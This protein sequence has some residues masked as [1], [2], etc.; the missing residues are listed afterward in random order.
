[1]KNTNQKFIIDDKF[2]QF[3]INQWLLGKPNNF[4]VVETGQVLL[5]RELKQSMMATT[6]EHS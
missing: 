2:K 3:V 5:I 6:K 1:L 4:V